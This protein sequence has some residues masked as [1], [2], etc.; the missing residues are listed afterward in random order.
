[1]LEAEVTD[2]EGRGASALSG[3]VRQCVYCAGVAQRVLDLQRELQRMLGAERPRTGI[4]AALSRAGARATAVRRR[5]RTWQTAIPLAAAAGLAG[6]LIY[7]G[8]R[9]SMPGSVW[10]A[11]EQSVA[12]GLDIETPP[13]QNVAVFEVADRPDIVVVWFYDQ[14]D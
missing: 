12:V 11:R 8:T 2:L 10:Q 14:G 13:R 3:H 6:I 1:M 7:G 4:D 9:S 5:R